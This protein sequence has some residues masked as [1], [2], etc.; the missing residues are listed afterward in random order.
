MT[1]KRNDKRVV[2]K[3]GET[4][5]P[6]I[7][8]AAVPVTTSPFCRA[9]CAL[10]VLLVWAVPWPASALTLELSG[11]V[12]LR[13][14]DTDQALSAARKTIL[15]DD[16][17]LRTTAIVRFS[18]MA[19][20]N[21]FS[22]S[23]LLVLQRRDGA[24]SAWKDIYTFYRYTVAP[25]APTKPPV[26]GTLTRVPQPSATDKIKQLKVAPQP[27]P[28]DNP[29]ITV[30]QDPNQPRRPKTGPPFDSPATTVPGLSF[31][32]PSLT[33]PVGTVAIR[34]SARRTDGSSVESVPL[35]LEV[36]RAPAVLTLLAM[37]GYCGIPDG[38]SDNATLSAGGIIRDPDERAIKCAAKN[39][40]PTLLADLITPS[41]SNCNNLCDTGCKNFLE[42]LA[43]RIMNDR[44]LANAMVSINDRGEQLCNQ[45]DHP[46]GIRNQIIVG[47]WKNTKEE[48]LCGTPIK[49]NTFIDNFVKQGGKSL[50]LIGQSLGG[51]MFAKMVRDHWSWGNNLTLELIVQWDATGAVPDLSG[52]PI[53]NSNGVRRLGS[54]PK[55]VLGFFQHSDLAAFQN[56]APLDPAEHHDNLEQHNL[57][58]CF[59]HNGI[60]RSQFVHRR[61]TDVVKET[62]QAVRNRARL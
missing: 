19:E 2:K 57:D 10:L 3:D 60:A 62:L 43:L 12:K 15:L 47:K 14:Q 13:P 38:N 8:G 61:T 16:E 5:Q 37:G 53:F 6:D 46:A 49:F 41:G 33:L 45:R 50:I 25:V 55:R 31:D 7:E 59:T 1:A 20:R 48:G 24:S 29:N 34:A 40:N 27:G 52:H 22:N 26:A 42:H 51:F 58:G 36:R 21:S 32:S 18:A 39:V 35:L 9:V 56:G 4:S 17:S 44:N 30:P 11:L 54:R 28:F 23:F